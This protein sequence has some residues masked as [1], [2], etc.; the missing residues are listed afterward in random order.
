MSAEV[1]AAAIINW[2]RLDDRVTT[3]GQPE[4][5]QLPILQALGIRHVINLA[6][7]SHE[8]A[9]PDEAASLAALG[10]G[11]SHIPVAF[12]HPT[13]SDFARFCDAFEAAKDAP[14]HV[15]CI[16]NYRVSAFLYRYRRQVEGMSE[17]QARTDLEK[18]WRPISVWSA[19]IENP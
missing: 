1:E 2:L 9:L 16:M 17:V 10:M 12:D 14:V 8:Q 4:A 15:H 6:L 13:E 11:Y 18:I 19:F 7:H 5:A 3:S